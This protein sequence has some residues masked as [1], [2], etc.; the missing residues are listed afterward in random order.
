MNKIIYLDN[1]ATTAVSSEVVYSM[2]PYMIEQYGN[3]STSYSLGRE[4]REVVENCRNRIANILNCDPAGLYFTSGGTESDN[5]LIKGI[6]HCFCK[7]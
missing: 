3:P 2:L 4:A 1:A 6:A 5:T 7:K